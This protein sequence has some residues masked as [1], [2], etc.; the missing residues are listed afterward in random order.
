MDDMERAYD[1]AAEDEAPESVEFDEVISGS[2]A[3]DPEPVPEPEDED[4][5]PDAEPEEAAPEGGQW[6]VYEG[7][8]AS[9]RLDDQTLKHGIPTYVSKEQA[10]TLLTHPFER[11]TVVDA[12]VPSPDEE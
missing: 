12:P 6:L 4:D 3:I 1:E 8:A 7:H 11:F 10:L 2:D 5:S 9:V